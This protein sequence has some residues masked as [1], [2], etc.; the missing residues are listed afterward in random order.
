MGYYIKI[1]NWETSMYTNDISE[2]VGKTL[3]KIDVSSDSLRF[4]TTEA[5]EYLM[6][7]DQDC[8]EH[9]YIEDMV[10]DHKDLLNSPIVLAE[11]RSSDE[12]AMSSYDEAYLWTF[13]ELATV[14]GSVTIRWYGSSNGYYSVSVSFRKM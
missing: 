13:Y 7:H 14:K 3:W 9:V 5:E 11:E 10:G 12:P 4:Y 8:C 2:L 1:I 6:Y